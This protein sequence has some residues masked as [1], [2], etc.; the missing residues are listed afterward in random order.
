MNTE[1]RIINFIQYQL[2]VIAWCGF[3]FIA[4]STPSQKIPGLENLSDKLVHFGVYA[5][6][7]WL[8][9]VAFFFQ[10]SASLKR[11]SITAAVLMAIV[12]GASDE[13][14]QTFTPGRSA[15]LYDLLAD[16]G[17]AL[18]YALVRGKLGLYRHE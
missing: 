7:C 6:L 5:V 10:S 16:T 4:S 8:F 11:H 12:F 18:F 17:G 2:P 3:I 13:Y 15:E 1:Q 14:H 9:H